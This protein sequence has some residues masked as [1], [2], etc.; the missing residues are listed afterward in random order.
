MVSTTTEKSEST[1][2]VSY[3][4]FQSCPR[5]TDLSTKRQE[6]NSSRYVLLTTLAE[7]EVAEVEVLCDLDARDIGRRK[8]PDLGSRS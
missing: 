5:R 2:D 4:P 7:L 8:E 1:S 3:Q 6:G